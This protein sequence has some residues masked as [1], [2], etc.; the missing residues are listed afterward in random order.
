[1]YRKFITTIAAASVALTA[2]G[3]TPAFADRDDDLGRA[4]AAVFGV[5]VIGAIIHDNKK[6][7]KA[8]RVQRR[9]H[10]PA[11][12]PPRIRDRTYVDPKPLP[13]KV[14]RKLLPQHCLR[15]FDT[16]RGSVQMFPRRCLERSYS[17]ISHLPQQCATRVRTD[18]GRLGGWDARCLRQ[19][20]YQLARR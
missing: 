8:H 10:Q 13:R 15:S 6:K 3:A 7:K 18:H 12:T 2:L 9:E 5:A 17:F 16:R 14:R 11:H 4:L 20:G 19:S 1:M